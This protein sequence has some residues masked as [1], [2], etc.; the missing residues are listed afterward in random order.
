MKKKMLRQAGGCLLVAAALFIAGNSNIG[1]LERGCD[2]VMNYM[3]VNYTAE[4]IRQGAQR[5]VKAVSAL[6]EKAGQAVSVISGKKTYGEPVNEKEEGGKKTVYAVGAGQVAE[7]G[8][9]EEMG[10]FIRIIHGRDGESVYGNL[11]TVYVEPSSRV[12]KGQVIGVYENGDREFY[13]SF[14]EFN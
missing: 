7:T 2:A 9:T 10:S 5:G 14:R 8:E 6:P 3:S 13:Y 11:S 12:R 4:E 1:V